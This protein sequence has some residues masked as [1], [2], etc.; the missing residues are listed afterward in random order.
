MKEKQSFSRLAST[1][2][3]QFLWSQ[4]ALVKHV[5]A[6][7][8]FV[9]LN[10]AC[11][12][13][14]SLHQPFWV[15]Y[16]YCRSSLYQF[17]QAITVLKQHSPKLYQ[18]SQAFAGFKLY[19]PKLYQLS[20]S[21]ARVNLCLLKL[22]KPSPALAESKPCV[23]NIYKPSPALVECKQHLLNPY[24]PLHSFS[25]NWWC[26]IQPFIAQNVW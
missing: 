3:E 8:T 2:L 5:P 10:S 9:G 14:A 26:F 21:F 19:F 24:Q 13:R 4:T 23:P 1:S 18:P 12:T 22:Y 6:F 11:W 20:T 17:S 16:S 15:A 7:I 25:N